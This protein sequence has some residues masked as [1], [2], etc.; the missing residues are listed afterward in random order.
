MKT[1][2]NN[3][4]GK[5]IILDDSGQEIPGIS[6]IEIAAVMGGDLMVSYRRSEEMMTDGRT[7]PIKVK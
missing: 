6:E 4:Q 1:I 2:T 3:E 7:F 5:E